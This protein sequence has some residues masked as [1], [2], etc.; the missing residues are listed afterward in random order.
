MSYSRRQIVIEASRREQIESY[1]NGAL[2]ARELLFGQRSD[3]RTE[4]RLVYRSNLIA[5]DARGGHVRVF[6]AGQSSASVLDQSE[7]S[8]RRHGSRP[9]A[10]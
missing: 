2:D 9:A 3:P 10:L 1:L 6:H 5:E 8:R 4:T 7:A